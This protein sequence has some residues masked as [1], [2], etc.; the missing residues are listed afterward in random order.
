MG[1]HYEYEYAWDV[2]Y[3]YPNSN[4]LRNKLDITDAVKLNEAERR[5][6]GISLLEIKDTPIKGHFD[7]KH[8]QAIHKYIFSDIY[9]WAGE[10]RTVNI[11]KGNPFCNC[12]YFDTYASELFKKLENENYLLDTPADHIAERLAYYLSEINIL[13]PFR[14]GN[15]RAQRV[16]IEYL[17]QI[18][19]YHADFS[20][21]SGKEMI[22]ASVK[23]FDCDYSAMND[24]FEKITTPIP[25]EEQELAIRKIAGARSRIMRIF[26]NQ[27]GGV[28]QTM[29]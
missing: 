1:N 6:T 16:F 5:Y 18:A 21:V 27:S 29:V 7:L 20:N 8:L 12:M 15:G 13:H 25:K 19:G 28:G 23:A 10:L 4:V 22:E 9:E 11:S 26:K 17:A 24:M 2:Y 3:C 14:E